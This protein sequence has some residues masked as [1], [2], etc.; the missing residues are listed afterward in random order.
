MIQRYMVV[1]GDLCM[2][3]EGRG[4]GNSALFLIAIFVEILYLTSYLEGL[5]EHRKPTPETAAV[6]YETH[7]A[8]AFR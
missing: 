3:F 2:L 1:K 4:M 5:K 7:G 6:G 8:L